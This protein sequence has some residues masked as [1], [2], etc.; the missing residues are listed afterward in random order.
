MP[1]TNWGWQNQNRP[2]GVIW[3]PGSLADSYARVSR[4]GG[5]WILIAANPSSEYYRALRGSRDAR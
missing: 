3:I 2:A 1:D 4:Y 5:R